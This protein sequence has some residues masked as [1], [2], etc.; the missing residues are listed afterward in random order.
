MKTIKKKF[1]QVI[2]FVAS[3]EQNWYRK[4]FHQANVVMSNMTSYLEDF[5]LMQSCDHMVMTVGT[6]GWWA[7]WM[8][9]HRGG[10]VMYYRDPF[11]VGSSMYHHFNRRSHFPGHWLAYGDNLVTKNLISFD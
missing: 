6:F 1:K 11:T 8:T 9:S 3:E 7:A 2:F 10:D 4:Q 5:V